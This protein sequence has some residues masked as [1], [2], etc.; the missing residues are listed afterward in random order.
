LIE[1]NIINSVPRQL[2]ELK[3]IS[4]PDP[5]PYSMSFGFDLR[6]LIRSIKK[7]GLINA[8]LLSEG[9]QGRWIVVTGYRRIQAIASLGWEKVPCRVIAES[10]AEPLDYLLLNLHDNLAT[11]KFNEV[12][13]AMVLSRLAIYLSRAE[14]IRHYMPLLD[15]PSHEPTFLLF[16]DIEEILDKDIKGHLAL[17][18]LSLHAARM[19]LDLDDNA[20]S[21]LNYLIGKLKLNV[22]QQKQLIDY[23]VDLSH[24]SHK[25]VSAFLE[26]HPVKSICDDSHMNNPQKARA[27]LQLLRRECYPA[28]SRSENA[29]KEKVSRLGLPTG[30][31]ITHPP[32]FEAAEHRLEIL[33]KDGREL[34]RKLGQ[35]RG[36]EGLEDLG[37]LWKESS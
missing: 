34:K 15:L 13:K 6:P 32:F 26:D 30:V 27:V 35:I 12:E 5:G 18:L 10:R 3:D 22:N 21:S 1:P 14:I 36:V 33:F 37:D 7:V 8:P 28:L 17:G 31:K 29:F 24:N 4:Q 23:I 11:R 25:S 20:R 19:L 16:R 9:G 2:I